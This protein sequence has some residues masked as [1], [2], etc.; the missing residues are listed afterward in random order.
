MLYHH[1]HGHAILIWVLGNLFAVVNIC[2]VPHNLV[3]TV[4]SLLCWFP[5]KVNGE[6]VRVDYQLLLSVKR[7]PSPLRGLP[8]RAAG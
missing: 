2:Q 8:E 1:P 4:C 6:G 7:T 3:I 5:Q